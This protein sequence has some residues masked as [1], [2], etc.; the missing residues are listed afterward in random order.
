MKAIKIDVYGK[1]HGVYFRAN[2]CQKAKALKINGTVKNMPDGSVQ[3]MAE[4]DENNLD[5]LVNWC[6]KGPLLAAVTGVKVGDTDIK[7][8]SEFATLK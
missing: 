4:G 5:Q 3:I 6:H 2:T 1:V 8:Y 7:G